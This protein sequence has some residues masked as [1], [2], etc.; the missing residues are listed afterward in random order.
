[1]F[2]RKILFISVAV[3]CFITLSFSDLDTPGL[4]FDSGPTATCNMSGTYTQIKTLDLSSGQYN[5]S[6]SPSFPDNKAIYVGYEAQA[7]GY[8]WVN[9]TIDYSFSGGS[10]GSGSITQMQ[11]GTLGGD[12]TLVGVTPDGKISE[13]VNI[14]RSIHAATANETYGSYTWNILGSTDP[15]NRKSFVK[16]QA[17]APEWR[18]NVGLNGGGSWIWKAWGDPNIQDFSGSG[19]W[20]VTGKFACPKC[21][22]V[23]VPYPTYHK[24]MSCPTSITQN[25]GTVYCQAGSDIWKCQAHTHDF[26][27]GSGSGGSDPSTDNT[28][29]CPDCTS[30]CSSPCSCSNS[31]TCNGTVTD[32]TPNCQDCTSHCSSPCSCSNSG[33]C[34]GTV[35]DN[36]PDCSYCTDGCSSCD[37]DDDDGGDDDDDSSSIVCGGAAWTGCDSSDITSRTQHYVPECSNCN[38]PY[39]TCSPYAS[40]HTA[41]PEPCKRSGCGATLTPCQNGPGKCVNG[42][43]HW[44]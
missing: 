9:A 21:K 14:S 32:S 18:Y 31:G 24:Y 19:S 13:N 33:T 6:W 20:N 28:P 36:T 37:S 17:V 42:G 30:D 27:S 12:L 38:N 40:R 16:L 4:S 34:N 11:V 39:W 2:A 7:S 15:G 8:G 3:L 43:Y 41:D 29:N 26:P 44:L 1:M 25:G 23:G 22:E 5:F 35:V 10:E